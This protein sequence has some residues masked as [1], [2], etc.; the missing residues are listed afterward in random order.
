MV[1]R[2]DRVDQQELARAPRRP[3]YRREYQVEHRGEVAVRGGIVDVFP[4]TADLP[5]ADRPVRRRGRPAHRVR[6]RRPALGGPYSTAVEIFGCRE[7]VPTDEVR[8]RAPGRS[9]PQNRG[10]GPL[11]PAG[12]RPVVRRDGVVAA[13]AVRDDRSAP[14][15]LGPDA[16][17]VLVEPGGRGT[18]RELSDEEAALAQALAQTWGAVAEETDDARSDSGACRRA[19][20]D[21]VAVPPAAPGIRPRCSRDRAA[22]VRASCRWPTAPAPR[23]RPRAGQPVLGDRPVWPPGSAGC[24]RTATAVTVCVEEA[25]RGGPAGRTC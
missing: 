10:A 14:D 3:G 25:R 9:W 11:G 6:S 4:S 16:R 24:R 5:G 19:D 12:R 1:S 20:G 15:L 23:G 2:G 13:V 21:R 22:P 17:V 8:E 18:G 7:L